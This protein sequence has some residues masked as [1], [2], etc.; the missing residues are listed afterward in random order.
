M[1]VSRIARFLT[2][3]F[4]RLTQPF[5][6]LFAY[7]RSLPPGDRFIAV[8]LAAIVILVSVVGLF[9]LLR[10]Q[11][12]EVPA[13]GGTLTEGVLGSPRFVNPLLALS[14]ADRDLT[15]LTFAGLMGIGQDGTLVP[16]LAREYSVSEDGKTYTFILRD[17][18]KFSDGTPVTAEDV[19]FTVEKAQDPSLK[20]P[21]YSN[22]VSIK[23]EAL[24][25]HTVQFTLPKPYAP[26]LADTTLG[27]LPS[28]LWRNVPNAEFP[29]SPLMQRPVGAGPFKVVNVV[30]NS[31]GLVT[32]YDLKAHKGY[33]LGR[34]YLDEIRLRFFETTT[35]LQGAY[36]S[37]RI[38]SAYGIDAPGALRAPYSRV[39]G[40]F[41]NKKEEPA[42]ARLEVR[43]ALSIAINREHIVHDLLGGY[44]TALA[45]PVSSGNG[46]V[47]P[48]LPAVDTRI[49]D[50]KTLLTNNGWKFDP[51]TNVWENDKAKL[52]LTAITIRT[53]NV[54]EL[55]VIAEAIQSDWQTI[56]IPTTLEFYEPGDLTKDVIRP[57]AYAA[58]LFG[59]VV[60][61][62]Q[63]LYAFWDSGE[64]TDPGL[65]IASYANAA[66]DSL[67]ERARS[68]S[69]QAKRLEY[70]QSASDKIAADYPAAFTHA[71]DFLYAIPKTLYGVT[72]PQIAAPA[73]RF[74]TVATWYKERAYVWPFLVQSH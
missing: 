26:F 4:V 55:K 46:I 72:L 36:R 17:N 15:A 12:V 41:F 30:E 65:N 58:L 59:M 67:L 43:K 34:P 52:S 47:P 69:D 29:F 25:A 60:G 22:W 35:L 20:S 71:P 18:A 7:I 53:S 14:D 1:N 74:A 16:V 5:R 56:G 57:R 3:L 50:A 62:E 19:V 37:G 6:R 9:S 49:E 66:V 10:S 27:I 64:Q 73:D 11:L 63:D 2:P 39:F 32:E 61:R 33:A 21:E 68:T 23:A 45:G 38:E 31:D 8:S 48:S 28:R 44:A 24:D 42:F 51:E 70:L 54:P 13:H 40:V